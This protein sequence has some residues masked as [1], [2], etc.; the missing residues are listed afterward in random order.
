MP[1]KDT[2]KLAVKQGSCETFS[3]HPRRIQSLIGLAAVHLIY[4]N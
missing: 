2:N 3:S 4:V 1:T